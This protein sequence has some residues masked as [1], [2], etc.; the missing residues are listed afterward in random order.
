MLELALDSLDVAAWFRGGDACVDDVT[1]LSYCSHC[2]G[3]TL[4]RPC[5]AACVTT[6]T[7]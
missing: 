4:I 2:Y 6:V 7:R 5:A 1:R 3:L